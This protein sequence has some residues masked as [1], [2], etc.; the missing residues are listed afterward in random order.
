MHRQV[1]VSVGQGDFELFDEQAF[2]ADFAQGAIQNLIALRGHAQQRHRMP[3]AAQ[4]RLDMFG[5]PHGEAA[6][7]GGDGQRKR[8]RHSIFLLG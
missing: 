4:Q 5:L 1:S 8:G 3:H 6:F 2:A 7:T